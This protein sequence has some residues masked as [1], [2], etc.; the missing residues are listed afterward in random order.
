MPLAFVVMM[1]VGG[2]LGMLHLWVPL[3]EPGVLVSI[4][5]F[6]LLVALAVDLP[7]SAGIAIIAFFA[8]FHGHA[9]GAEA[10]ENACGLEYMAGF[11]VATAFLHGVGIATALGFGLRCREPTPS[12][13]VM[14]LGSDAVE[15]FQ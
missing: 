2:G 12:K 7:I 1:L 8:L 9:H 3:I 10:P 5:A 11:A 6:G 14:P 15:H 4:V 13:S